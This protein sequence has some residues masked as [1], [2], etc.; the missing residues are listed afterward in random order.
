MPLAAGLSPPGSE[1]ETGIGPGSSPGPVDDMETISDTAASPDGAGALPVPA[2]AEG[3]APL[4]L[5]PGM[6]LDF[7]AGLGERPFREKQ[8]LSWIYAHDVLDAAL[9]SDLPAPLREALAGVLAPPQQRI[10]QVSRS[11]DG[12]RKL[13]VELDD[14]ER[15]E[16]VLIPDGD[17]LTLCVSTQVGCAMGCTFCAT[18]RLGLKRHLRTD[19]IVGQVVLARRE[20]AAD[21]LGP[22]HLTNLV[23]MGLGEPLHN[24]EALL[25]AIR[26]LTEQWG[27]SISPRRITVSTVGVVPQMRR[28]LEETR[29][30]LAVSLGATTEEGR[31]AIMPVTKR[32]SLAE[33]LE[34]CREL[35]LKRRERITFEYTMLAGENDSDDDAR[36]MVRLLNGIRAKVNLIFWNPF[37]GAEHQRT[38]RERMQR[39]QRVLLDN[40]IH[41]TIR[42][43]RGPDIQAA[44]GQLA[45]QVESLRASGIGAAPTD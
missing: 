1:R 43:S 28:L 39:F 18:A 17:R 30:K 31:R 32:W 14:G 37:E 8:I 27:L 7:L 11:S 4:A 20:M 3:W 36:R 6:L 5:Q 10:A 16:S 41:A 25:P 29:V 21:P 34:T 24:V 12:T 26:I 45:A 40:A 42:E 2:F 33:L 13:L 22:G 44:C 23:F 15:I 9:M 35:P 19:E 38:S